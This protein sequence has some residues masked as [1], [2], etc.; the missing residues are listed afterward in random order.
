MTKSPILFSLGVAA[1]ISGG[2]LLFWLGASRNVDETAFIFAGVVFL[3]FP[4]AWFFTWLI[5][6]AMVW[7]QQVS[8]VGPERPE[9]GESQKDESGISTSAPG[10]K[11]G[12]KGSGLGKPSV[13][14]PVLRL[15]KDV[16]KAVVPCELHPSDRP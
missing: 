10:Q 14:N 5:V 16:V 8:G 7:W 4:F 15:R 3:I 13:R 1:I 11:K 2:L 6:N 9:S 12:L